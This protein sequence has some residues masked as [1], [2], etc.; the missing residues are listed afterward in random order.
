M[1]LQHLAAVAR[2]TRLKQAKQLAHAC[3]RG[4]SSFDAR[5]T[6][7]DTPE[8]L[9]RV[10]WVGDQ[11]RRRPWFRK[12]HE[13]MSKC[14]DFGSGTGLL[15]FELKESWSHV[16]GLDASSGMLK[17]MQEKIE[18]AGLSSKMVA[19]EGPL[20]VLGSFDTIVSLLCIHHI[21]DCET[22]LRELATH[23]S[24]SGRLV[25]IDF[26]A[27]EHA[28]LF[29]KKSETRGDHYEHDGL[30]ADALHGW[31]TSAGLQN[32]EVHRAPFEKARAEGWEDAGRK[33]TF[34]MLIASGSRER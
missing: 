29:H 12:G 30:E 33:E 24:P 31:L 34:Q 16:T 27:T 5:A 4:N 28:R 21:R 9:Q 17:V 6:S 3:E 1:G 32:V 11:I 20:N 26:E 10:A 8:K 18:I 7:W 2:R 15:S 19:T 23:L 14:L 25:V 22:Q 13:A